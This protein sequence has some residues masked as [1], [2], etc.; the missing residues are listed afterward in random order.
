VS[1][2][3]Q[4]HGGVFTTTKGPA[5]QVEPG[6]ILVV[7]RHTNPEKVERMAMPIRRT[8]PI[9]LAGHGARSSSP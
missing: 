4:W 8:G 1:V 9:V 2:I 6:A 3:G 7:G 5:T